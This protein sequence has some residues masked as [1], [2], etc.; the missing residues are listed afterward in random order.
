M[1]VPWKMHVRKAACEERERRHFILCADFL[2]KDKN[3]RKLSLRSS[4]HLDGTSR[5]I[6]LVLLLSLSLSLSNMYFQAVIQGSSEKYSSF[7]EKVVP[8]KKYSGTSETGKRAT[9]DFRSMSGAGK[10]QSCEWMPSWNFFSG[11]SHHLVEE[12]RKKGSKTNKKW[13][14]GKKFCF[15]FLSELF[16]FH[17]YSYI[18]PFPKR[19]GEFFE[20]SKILRR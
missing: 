8:G 5:R 10:V 15:Y 16:F 18:R 1:F 7:L 9:R 14:A 13:R 12:V 2:G 19:T 11:K 3:K 6:H 20:S 4:L 17:S